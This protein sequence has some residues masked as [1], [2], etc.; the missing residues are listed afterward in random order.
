M[1]SR[2]VFAVAD[3]P[4]DVAEEL[5]GPFT[6]S[7]P[8]SRDRRTKSSSSIR[9]APRP[10]LLLLNPIRFDSADSAEDP[11]RSARR[12]RRHVVRVRAG[13]RPPGRGRDVPRHIRRNGPAG[14]RRVRG[15]HAH[16]FETPAR[17]GGQLLTTRVRRRGG[18]QRSAGWE[19][20][21]W[22]SPTCCSAPGHGVR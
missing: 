14:L 19:C 13:R 16:P 17:H 11:R 3:A 15:G 8:R 4:G 5:E 20:G 9:A 6:A 1:Q 21:R 12:T 18:D 10:L 22:G 2:V 7:V